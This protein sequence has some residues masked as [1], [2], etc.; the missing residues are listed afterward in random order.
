M[1]PQAPRPRPIHPGNGDGRELVPALLS[2]GETVMSAAQI[3]AM[4]RDNLAELQGPPK[5]IPPPAEAVGTARCQYCRT[6]GPLGRCQ[7]C[8][9]PNEPIPAPQKPTFP[10]NRVWR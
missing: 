3:N 6:Y 4:V 5:R 9:A 7:G 10:P 1:T 8:G 2:P